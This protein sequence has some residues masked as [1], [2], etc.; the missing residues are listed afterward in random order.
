M[1]SVNRF[2]KSLVVHTIVDT[3]HSSG[4]RFLKKEFQTGK[5]HELSDQQA[6]EKVGHAIRDA[7]NAHETKQ[8]KE[9]GKEKPAKKVKKPAERRDSPNSESEKAEGSSSSD[10]VALPASV[11]NVPARAA[12][13]KKSND[14]SPESHD[15][16]HE[17]QFLAQ[18]DA[19]LGPLP[20]D[21][22][23]PMEPLLKG[24]K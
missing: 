12:L 16:G 4:G 17:Q 19:I 24:K 5:W 21:A 2:G 13:P 10:L 7:V 22:E 3:I 8:A 9:H 11:P 18:I 23:D 20:P 6:K 14:S 1:K 15:E